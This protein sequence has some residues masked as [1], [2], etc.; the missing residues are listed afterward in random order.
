MGT[1]CECLLLSDS[2]FRT[3]TISGRRS[4]WA[5]LHAA[6]RAAAL[7]FVIGEAVALTFYLWVG[8]GIWFDGDEWDFLTNRSAG[9]LHDLFFPHSQHWSTLPILAY[10]FWWQVVGIRSYTPY[11]ASVVVLHLTVAALLRAVM[12]RAGVSPWV[13][14]TAALVFAFFGSG[15]FD[16]LYGFQIGFCGSLAFGLVYLLATGHDGPFDRRDLFGLLAGLASL[17]CS[18]V[19]VTMVVAVVVAV[20]IRRGWRVALAHGLPLA[21]IYLAWF[22]WIGHLGY[23]PAASPGQTL[24]FA[25]TVISS[26]FAALGHGP[27]VG[28]LLAALLVGGGTMAWC[29]TAPG[30]RHKDLAA[31][32][33]LLV[34]AVVFALVTGAGRGAPP[35]GIAA[36][37]VATKSRYL[38]VIAALSIP[39]LALAADAVIRRWR[40]AAPVV[41]VALLIGVP[42]NMAVA[43]Q[44][45]DENRATAMYFRP[46]ILTLPR[47]PVAKVLPPDIHPDIYFDPVMTLG[48]L[49]AGV[50][51][52]R[53]PPPPST[54]AT[55]VQRATS[56]PSSRRCSPTRH[57]RRRL[58]SGP[59][60]R[61]S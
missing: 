50:A 24:H 44:H 46:F 60:A 23:P 28:F 61:H 26:T 55:P 14:T 29:N 19:G 40:F 16:I 13:A 32:L 45:G 39:T 52:G 43:V 10:R 54:V 12:R 36:A 2:R 41:L 7:V 17:M 53:I 51:Q 6:A 20:V 49:R 59:P 5:R 47:L 42:G 18:G 33:A 37:Q 21:A 30:R 48:W 22:A 57:R 38:H 8:R 56:G 58:P 3:Q 9:S 1:S 34:G 35:A 31:P 15:Y 25:G 4:E 11:L 27:V